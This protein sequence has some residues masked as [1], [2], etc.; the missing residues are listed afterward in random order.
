MR[1]LLLGFGQPP[2]DRLAQRGH[3][4]HLDRA[5]FRPGSGEHVVLADPAPRPGPGQ[6]AQIDPVTRRQP[7]RHW[8]G[9][10]RSRRGRR[11]RPDERQCRG[12]AKRLVDVLEHD[13]PAPPGAADHADIDAFL[14]GA[15]ARGGADRDTIGDRRAGGRG[16]DDDS[17]H[18]LITVGRHARI[19]GAE[20]GDERIDRPRIVGRIAEHRQQRTHGQRLAS[21]R[22]DPD[23]PPVSLGLDLVGDLVGFDEGQHVTARKILAL[24]NHPLTD[25]AFRHFDAPF[26][27]GEGFQ[28]HVYRR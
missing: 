2:R 28:R 8:R 25:H 10:G 9:E 27:H 7:P 11:I 26:G 20:G 18:R 23:K 16:L 17:C 6:P 3:R 14:L 13:P 1:D 19:G 15:G 5:R 24:G 12:R 4:D 21:L 22:Q